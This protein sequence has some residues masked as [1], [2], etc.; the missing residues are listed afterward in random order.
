MSDSRVACESLHRVIN[1]RLRYNMLVLKV[2]QFLSSELLGNLNVV[3]D[4]AL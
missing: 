4:E 1:L 2:S 3:R